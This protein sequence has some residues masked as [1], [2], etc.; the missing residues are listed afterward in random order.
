MSSV[1]TKWRVS[2]VPRVGLDLLHEIRLDLW[3]SQREK[4]HYLIDRTG[5]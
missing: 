3:R 4:Y 1:E 5:H 2:S